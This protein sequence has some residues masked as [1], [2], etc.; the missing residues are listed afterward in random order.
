MLF[1]LAVSTVLAASAFAAVPQQIN[2]Q[3][4][5]TNTGG[6]PLDTTVAMTFKLYT[7]SLA[8]SLLWTE[9][10][11]LVTVTDGLFNVRLGQGTSL[12]DNVFNNAQVWLGITVGDNS[13]MSPRS[14]IVSVGY[15][16]R[17]G[18]VDG[19]SGGTV[20]GDVN[21][22]GKAN[23]GSGNTNTGTY[24][25]VVG[26]DGIASGTN[27]TVGGGS[28]NRARGEYSVVAGGGGV[29]PVDSNSASGPY[30]A[31][32]GGRKNAASAVYTTVGGGYTNA[33]STHY[34]TV[35]GGGFNAASDSAAAVGGGRYNYAR[36]RYSVVAGGGGASSAD[37]SSAS[38]NYSAIGGGHKNTASGTSATVGGGYSNTASAAYT[39]VGG[40]EINTASGYDA[41]VGG[42]YTNTA[43]NTNATVGGGNTNA[44]SGYSATVGGGN[45]NRAI[46]DNSTVGGG[47]YNYARGSYSVV[48]GGGGSAASD[49]NSASGSNSAIG[50]GTRNIASYSYATVGGGYSNAAS[51]VYATVAGGEQNDA[52]GVHATVA[53]GAQN[54]ASGGYAT[55]GGGGANASGYGATVGGGY[56]NAASGVYATVAG[57]EQNDAS[58]SYA[59]VGGG[60]GNDSCA[61]YATIPGGYDNCALGDYSFAAG[62][63]AKAYHSGAFVWADQTIAD[64]GSSAINQFNVRASGGTRI[65]SNSILTSGVTL[66]AGAGAW[67][68]VSDSTK[69][70]NLRP[71]NTETILDKVSQLP[72]R[73]WSYKSQNPSIEHIGPM[74]QDFWKLFHLGEDS[75]GISTIDPDGIALAA[76][77][78]LQKQNEEL[79][80]AVRRYA[81]ELN[82]LRRIVEQMAVK[83]QDSNGAKAASA[84][85]SQNTNEPTLKEITQ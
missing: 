38:G 59:T 10:R 16:Y 14:R 3:G 45:G 75:L 2:Y 35:S 47:R 51:G 71:V 83:P 82:D 79:R 29:S 40:G 8:G 34:A 23:I 84:A 73:Q 49:S 85:L 39:T 80:T 76:I 66:A 43:S 56:S 70:R 24:A 68:A 61:S 21:I 27:A 42:G 31:I 13:E 52:S 5:L 81:E 9:T 4:C 64:F 74:A 26:Q 69:K 54:D 20:T 67:V 37:S 28:Y 46:G 30:S 1:L 22:V 36:G 60:Y 33:A 44:A 32:G 55:V 65:Y 62:R 7:D 17:V 18:T 57:G 19:A 25:F 50:G 72:I 77:Q 6:S 63:R 58:G 78:E 41:T 53:G 15:S 48:A 12:E 11:P